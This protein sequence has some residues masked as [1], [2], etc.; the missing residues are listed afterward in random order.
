MNDSGVRSAKTT[1]SMETPG[2]TL[3]TIR[4]VRE[5]TAG[6]EDGLAGFSDEKQRLC[7]AI[8]LWN[9]RDPIIK[10]RLF[11][12]ANS[13]GN[14]GEDVKELYYYLDALP[15]YAYAR[16]LYKLPQAPYPT[17]NVVPG[18]RRKSAARSASGVWSESA[19]RPE[20]HR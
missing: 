14:H 11:G 15:S 20:S 1:A 17:G 5:L 9:G 4:L 7:F 16:M 19:C 18:P 10:E 12:L 2:D 6:G 8:A 13:E 3:V